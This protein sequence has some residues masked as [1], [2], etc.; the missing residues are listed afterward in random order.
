VVSR[1]YCR[2]AH[3]TVSLLPSFAAAHLPGTLDDI[4]QAVAKYETARDDGATV[5]QAA[6]EL[7]PDIGL[8]GAVCWVR[9]R[10]LWVRTAL[11]L[12]MGVAPEM[13]AQCELKISYI[14]RAWV[15]PHVLVQV[16]EI[17]QGSLC[18]AA[19]PVGL[20]PRKTAS[21]AAQ[22]GMGADPPA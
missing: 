15:T 2:Q 18:H 9:R 12:V 11:M 8:Q 6:Q 7:R 14:R 17:A 4:E 13:L 1:W 21:K 22:H 16:R 20:A 3:Q 10:L 19:P 5:A